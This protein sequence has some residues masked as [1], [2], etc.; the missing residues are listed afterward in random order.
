ML[1]GERILADGGLGAGALQFGGPRDFQLADRR[2]AGIAAEDAFRGQPPFGEL[3][4]WARTLSKSK[5]IGS[6]PGQR[7]QDLPDFIGGLEAVF[8]VLGH[9]FLDDL[10]DS[11]RN[12]GIQFPDGACAAVAMA[13]Q[14]FGDALAGERNVAGHQEI[15]RAAQAIDVSAAVH[16]QAV[17][18]LSGAM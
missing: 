6:A 13:V 10:R 7:R 3:A 18:R 11:L 15:E 8:R 5:S 17:E 12:L 4:R 2:R 1:L 14:F 16:V 9:H